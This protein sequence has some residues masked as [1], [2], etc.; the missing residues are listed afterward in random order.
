[1]SPNSRTAAIMSSLRILGYANSTP[2]TF[3]VDRASPHSHV[4]AVFLFKNSL[5]F[6]LD[7]TGRH[8][9]CLTVSVPSQGGLYTSSN[10]RLLASAVCTADVV[11]GADWLA[12]CRATTMNNVLLQPSPEIVAG[13][14]QQR[15][16]WSE[17]R[18]LNM[19]LP[20][21]VLIFTDLSQI[22]T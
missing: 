8:H 20:A 2:T 13:A 10:F 15:A 3:L 9:A 17:W 5:N 6:L 19:L 14:E 12:L 4:S 18:N 16:R 7:S 22:F 1:M 21:L 11:L